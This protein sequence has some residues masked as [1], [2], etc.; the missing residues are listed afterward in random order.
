MPDK[1][2]S[3]DAQP[4]PISTRTLANPRRSRRV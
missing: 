2:A 1:K 3:D 4:Q